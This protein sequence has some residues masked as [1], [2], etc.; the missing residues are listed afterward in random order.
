ME[1]VKEEKGMFFS[2]LQ[3]NPK[4]KIADSVCAFQWISLSFLLFVKS[5]M[6]ETPNGLERAKHEWKVVKLKKKGKVATF[7][8]NG[9]NTQSVRELKPARVQKKKDKDKDKNPIEP[10]ELLVSDDDIEFHNENFPLQLDLLI[11]P[12]GDTR[13]DFD[14]ECQHYADKI[15]VHSDRVTM[16]S[17]PASMRALYGDMV[18]VFRKVLL[19]KKNIA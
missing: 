17:D 6:C 15:G 9:L 3:P 4:D 1:K 16:P 2:R 13:K 14:F 12:K 18:R 10:W 7:E 5:F 11:I 8:K 19:D